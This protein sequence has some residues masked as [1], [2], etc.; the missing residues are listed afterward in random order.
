M[1]GGKEV[2]IVEEGGGGGRR[3]G[4]LD[5]GKDGVTERERPWEDKE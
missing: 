1:K 2:L 4:E 5:G 3:D